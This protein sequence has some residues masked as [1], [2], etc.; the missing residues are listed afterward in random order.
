MQHVPENWSMLLPMAITFTFDGKFFTKSSSGA[1]FPAAIKTVAIVSGFAAFPG[2]SLQAVKLLLTE[3]IAQVDTKGFGW[4]GTDSPRKLS[5][6]A[7]PNSCCLR[8]Q[9]QAY[10][11]FATVDLCTADHA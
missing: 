1:S 3:H 10:E 8:C 5:S 9:A 6:R 4:A 11:G 7:S 2:P